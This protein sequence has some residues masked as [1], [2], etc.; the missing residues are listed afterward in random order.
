[1]RIFIAVD[2]PDEIRQKAA[3]MGMEIAGDG[4]IPVP[5]RNMHLTL[6]FI[7]E[8]GEQGLSE[9]LKRLESVRFSR[10]GCAIRGVGVFPKPDFVRVV[11][12]G[13]ESDGALESLANSVA[14][15]LRGFGRDEGEYTPHLTVARVK[16]KADFRQ[17]LERHAGDEFGSFEVDRFH[18]IESALGGGGPV[19]SVVG[20][21]K[22]VDADA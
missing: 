11:W 17:F 6:R 12:A 22:A 8:T 20:T 16:R 10:F 5:S 21:Y 14:S 9:I 1:M 15:A 4:I 3:A 18:V 7:G 2:I 13:V 19:Y